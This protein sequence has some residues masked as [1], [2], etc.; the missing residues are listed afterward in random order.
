MIRLIPT[1]IAASVAAAGVFAATDAQWDDSAPLVMEVEV[2]AKDLARCQQT[3]R[4]LAA[5]PVVT[6]GG[7][8]AFFAN[9]SDLPTVVCVVH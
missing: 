6:D 3:L 4:D 7:H 1:A 5:Q 2:A 9:T 8:S